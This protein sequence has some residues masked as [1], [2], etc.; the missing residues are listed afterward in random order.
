MGIQDS[1][2]QIAAKETAKATSSIVGA[3]TRSMNFLQKYWYFVA[4]AAFVLGAVA[5][6]A[7]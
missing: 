3:E 1:L 2:N 6:H 4:A 7:L 5:G